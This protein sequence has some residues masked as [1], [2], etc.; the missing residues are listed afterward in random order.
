MSEAWIIVLR[1]ACKI[2]SQA[3]VATQIGMSPAVV[4]QVL[5]GT[6]NG[7]LDNVQKRVEGA[8]MGITVDCP[9]IGD[10]PLNRCIENQSRPFAATNP[11]RVM[12]HRACKTCRN[13]RNTGGSDE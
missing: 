3:A 9:V 5:K 4:N 6:Y 10:I 7:R 12:L 1:K 13:N 11:L 2:N 8:L